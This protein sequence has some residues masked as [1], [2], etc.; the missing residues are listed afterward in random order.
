MGA[1]GGEVGWLTEKTRMLIGGLHPSLA[2]Y[3]GS[4][5]SRDRP[6]N[7]C[8]TA[9]TVE[10]TFGGINYTCITAVQ[11]TGTNLHWSNVGG[12][13]YWRAH[14]R[15]VRLSLVRLTDVNRA[16]FGCNENGTSSKPCS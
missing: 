12:V 14:K 4:S 7:A 10:V 8:R 3:D 11:I 2:G 1:M 6:S 16:S 15:I 5:C 9:M 13:R